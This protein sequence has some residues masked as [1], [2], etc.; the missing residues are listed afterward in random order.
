MQR[1]AGAARYAG[2]AQHTSVVEPMRRA[3]ARLASHRADADREV[4]A[5]RR[6]DRRCGRTARCRSATCGWRAWNS[7]IAPRQ[8]TRAE[9]HAAGEPQRAAR[10]D[11]RRADR[12]FGFL[13][14]GEQLQR[15]LEERL[16]AFGQRQ[17]AR[18][19]VE[20]ARAQMRLELGDVA[21][22]RRHREVEPLGR[23]GRSCRPRRRGRTPRRRESGP[24]DYCV[25]RNSLTRLAVFI[26]AADAHPCVEAGNRPANLE[27]AR[28][29][30]YYAPAACSLAPHIALSRSR[31]RPRARP[32]R[33]AHAH[34]AGRHRLPRR[35]PEGLRAACS[36]STTA[37]A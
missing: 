30:L 10:L 1:R 24:C 26:S 33:P 22:Q 7:A 23:R 11:G 8:V 20:Q 31:T 32:R 2:A 17:P 25:I 14:V 16:A 36:S 9:R 37:R 21:R 13:E 35:Q 3:I 12:R 34:A 5:L 19:A 28:M 18:G 4:E 27:G 15:A 29:K 6:R